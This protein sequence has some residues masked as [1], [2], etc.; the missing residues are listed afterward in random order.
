MMKDL[1][2]SQHNMADC[3]VTSAGDVL[4]VCTSNG[5]DEAHNGIPAPQAPSFI[6]VTG[7]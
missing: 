7:L 1:G 3:S 5:V 4:F 2:V 6:A